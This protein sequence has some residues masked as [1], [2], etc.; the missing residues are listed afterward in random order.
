MHRG[1]TGTSMII[2]RRSKKKKNKK[3]NRQLDKLKA[4]YKQDVVNRHINNDHMK[5]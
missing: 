4:I 5:G 3:N 1:S 2:V